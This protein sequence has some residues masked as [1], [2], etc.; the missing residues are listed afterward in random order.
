M[1]NNLLDLIIDHEGMI[2][3]VYDDATGQEVGAGDILVGHPTIG[4]GRNIAKDGLG[5]SEDEAK[6]LLLNDILRVEAEIKDFPIEHLGDVRKA[7]VID[8]AFNMGITRFNPK[9][10][11]NF[12]KAIEEKNWTKAS[13]EMV[14]SLWARQTKRRAQ[15]LSEMMISGKWL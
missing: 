13:S 8:M 1:Q 3:K 10:W 9:K 15:R 7:V 2:L 11:P 4:V 12:F 5:I 6:S 14:S